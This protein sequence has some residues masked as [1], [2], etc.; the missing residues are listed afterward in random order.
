MK[1][2]KKRLIKS[3][4][5][6]QATHVWSQNWIMDDVPRRPINKEAVIDVDMKVSSLIQEER[7]WDVLKLHNLFPINDVQRILQLPVG[8][9]ADIDI[10]AFTSNGAYTVKSGY[11]LAAKDKEAQ[12]LDTGLSSPG[13]LELKREI[14]KIPT[15]PKMRSFLWRAALG[16]LAVAERLNTR[17]MNVDSLCKL[18]RQGSESI[19]HVLFYCEV[20]QEVWALAVFQLIIPPMDSTLVELLSFYLRKISDETIPV[21]QRRSIPWIMWTIWRNRNTILYADR[22]ESLTLQVKKASDE[23]HIWHE[24]NV[25]Q[26]NSIQMNGVCGEVKRWEPPLSG[27]AK[28]N[29][30]ANWR[31]AK[32]HSG[33]AFII[34]D[35]SSNV[36]HHA[37]DA[38]TFSPNRLTA[39]LRCL[40]WALQSMQNLGYQDIVLGFDLH[41]LVEAM[42]KP[43]NWPRFRIIIQR[44]HALCSSFGS[45]AFETET[46]ASNRVAREIAKSVLRNGLFQ[47]YL[48][49]GGPD[50]LHQQIFREAS[51]I[52]S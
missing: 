14:W 11:V 30:H 39:K 52:C 32:L 44:I 22:Q 48:A 15:I 47:S 3:I 36:L 9:V 33:I 10:W 12:A 5:N 29:I 37:R 24:L 31:N 7:Q 49:L 17:G 21:N 6:G 19:D 2:L 16:A 23:A 43:S 42:M 28:C 34:R 50:R 1:L 38:H 26:Q 27:F 8:D 18:C 20:A 46:I 51:S 40:E 41:D 4:G 45:I 13:L 25:T 35:H